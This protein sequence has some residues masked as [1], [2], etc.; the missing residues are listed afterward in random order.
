MQHKGHAISKMDCWVLA[1]T[2]VLGLGYLPFAP[3]TWGTL[4]ALPLYW[5]LSH[6]SVPVAC[7]ATVALTVVAVALSDRAEAIYR[8]H[9]VQHIV[10]DEVV[11][12]LWAVLAVPWRLPQIVAAFVLFRLLDALKPW[13]ISAVDKQVR[14]G[15]GVVLDDVVAGMLACALLHGTRIYL[16]GWWG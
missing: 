12:L 11:G 6:T 8:G 13:P 15:L 1:A 9:D 14:G 7:L 3:G 4:G 5:L 16:G 2:S 10:I